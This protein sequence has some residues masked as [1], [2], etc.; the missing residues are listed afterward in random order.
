MNTLLERIQPLSEI[1][2]S[3]AIKALLP[4]S[5]SSA[6]LSQLDADIKRMAFFSARNENAVILQR[7]QDLINSILQPE[8]IERGGVIVEQGFN[9]AS[10]RADLKEFGQ[11]IGY[12]APQG[13][14]GTIQDLFSDQRL[15]LVLNTNADL[16]YGWGHYQQSQNQDV[17]DAY[18]AWEL[19]RAEDRKVPRE[20]LDRWQA[21]G[22]E[23]YDGRMIATKDSDVWQNLGDGAG[24]Y[25][26]TLGNPFPPF[27]F[28]S[29]MDVFDIDRQDAIALGVMTA[30]ETVESQDVGIADSLQ[31]SPPITSSDLRAALLASQNDGESKYKFSGDTLTANEALDPWEKVYEFIERIAA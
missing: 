13:K 1:L 16:A 21:A 26:D 7:I 2:K 4:T 22:G 30:D 14:S 18:P 20:W 6:Q 27:A 23:L 3:N 19:A 17:L 29:G 8:T 31:A 5:L 15:T 28:N 10:A 12:E 11:S 25:D 9:L 24:G